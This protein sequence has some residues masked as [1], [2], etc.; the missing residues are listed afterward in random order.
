MYSSMFIV[1]IVCP[2]WQERPKLIEMHIPKIPKQ[3]IKTYKAIC[4]IQSVGGRMIRPEWLSLFSLFFSLLYN[5][6]HSIDYFNTRWT[7]LSKNRKVPPYFRKDLS[8]T[9]M[10]TFINQNGKTFSFTSV[11]KPI[12]CILLTFQ[13]ITGQER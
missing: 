9:K 10:V 4:V 2:I 3:W 7:I 5:S 11:S 12:N 6:H 13:E 8:K 1:V